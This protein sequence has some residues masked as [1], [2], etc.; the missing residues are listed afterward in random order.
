MGVS[1]N[2]AFSIFQLPIIHFATQILHKPFFLNAPGSIAFS[3]EH[4][5]TISYAK[6]GG[7]TECIMGNW[8]KVNG[9]FYIAPAHK[10]YIV[11]WIYYTMR[12]V[13]Q[14]AM[15]IRTMIANVHSYYYTIKFWCTFRVISINWPCTG[16]TSY[17]RNWNRFW[18]FSQTP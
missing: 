9:I 4:F 8:K 1:E 10:Y 16:L 2:Q 17:W 13:L 18:L 3:Q 7:Q 11:R 15:I 6:F 14:S 5:M 12:Q